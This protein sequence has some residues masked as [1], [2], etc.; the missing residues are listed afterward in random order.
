MEI[1][2]EMFIHWIIKADADTVGHF[3][4]KSGNAED[5]DP[6]DHGHQ[7]RRPGSKQ[8]NA[9]ND[10]R[11]GRKS[12]QAIDLPRESNP[13]YSRERRR[14]GNYS[15]DHRNI[16]YSQDRQRERDSS[17]DHA[18]PQVQKDDIDNPQVQRD[19]SREHAN[20]RIHQRERDNSRRGH[21]FNDIP[22]V[23][24]RGRE[25]NGPH[26][27]DYVDNPR[28]RDH[29]RER[30]YLR[31]YEYYVNLPRDRQRDRGYLSEPTW[32]RDRIQD[33]W[34]RDY[35]RG[36]LHRECDYSREHH[37]IDIPR[38]RRPDYSREYDY[39]DNS[40]DRQRE[41]GHSRERTCRREGAVKD[42]CRERYYH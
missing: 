38:V 40:W 13:Q 15:R 29:Q 10:S 16:K 42:C 30:N 9:D 24:Q 6:R 36:D 18:E 4:H 22:P 33:S 23:R 26:E 11:S 3:I 32:P 37:Y 17:R 8:T 39:I 41:G 2:G 7:E 31:E 28:S 14:E 19:Y 34:E 35:L 27:H 20:P 12:P 21:D 5:A 1:K 25:H